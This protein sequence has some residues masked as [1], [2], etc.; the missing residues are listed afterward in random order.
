M[1]IDKSA[2]LLYVG[3]RNKSRNTVGENGK[4]L[5]NDKE[6]VM[7]KE[8]KTICSRHKRP[9]KPFEKETEID[10]NNVGESILNGT[11]NLTLKKLKI[12]ND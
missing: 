1:N 10:V 7:R 4:M 6:I 8:I 5:S 9:K 12:D 3:K 2:T 11:C